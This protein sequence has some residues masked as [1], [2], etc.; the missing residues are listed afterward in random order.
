MTW[1]CGVT[2]TKISN[3]GI[4]KEIASAVNQR[5]AKTSEK[6]QFGNSGVN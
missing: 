1:L 3:S 4:K 5:P 2:D 6:F